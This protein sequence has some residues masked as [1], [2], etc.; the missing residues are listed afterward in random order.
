MANLYKFLNKKDLYNSIYCAHNSSVTGSNQY[1]DNA[2]SIADICPAGPAA[3]S[4]YQDSSGN[5][6]A[7]NTPATI[8]VGTLQLAPATSSSSLS[9]IGLTQAT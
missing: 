6:L 5:N 1:D 8:A 3:S 9:L 4:T 2:N 7:L